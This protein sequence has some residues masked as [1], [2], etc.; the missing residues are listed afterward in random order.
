MFDA[1]QPGWQSEIRANCPTARKVLSLHQNDILA[2]ERSDGRE[3][4]RIVKFSQN[5]QIAL[6]APN[7]G[8]KPEVARQR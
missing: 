7:E 3:L 5:G 1:H 4:L 2:V 8:G 6:A